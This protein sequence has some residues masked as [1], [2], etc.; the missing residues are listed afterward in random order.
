MVG[1]AP[2]AVPVH[3][4]TVPPRILWF[5][6]TPGRLI[7]EIRANDRP[8]L[9]ALLTGALERAGV[10]IDWAKV[11][12]RGSMVDDV[13][14]IVLP[15]RSAAAKAAG[16]PGSG[17]RGGIEQHLLAVLAP[18]EDPGKLAAV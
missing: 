15:P 14:C 7:I 2:T 10:N 8:G 3:H 4:S 16:E 5:D 6:G 18:P 17:T 13:F 9:L 11:T 12:T 1:D